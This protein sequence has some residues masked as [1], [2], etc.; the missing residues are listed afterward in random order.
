[1]LTAGMKVVLT[2]TFA[3][4]GFRDHDVKFNGPGSPNGERTN[5]IVLCSLTS[6]KSSMVKRQRSCNPQANPIV[7]TSE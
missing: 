4:L 5:D 6:A 3:R 7:L 2:D 1:M